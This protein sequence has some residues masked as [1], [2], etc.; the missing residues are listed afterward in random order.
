MQ[1]KALDNWLMDGEK[2]GSR[3]D[4]ERR[5]KRLGVRLTAKMLTN[6]M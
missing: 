6:V 2:K 3:S 5:K 1:W 4:F